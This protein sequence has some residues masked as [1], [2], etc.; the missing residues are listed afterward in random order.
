[1]KSDERAQSRTVFHQREKVTGCKP[2][3]VQ[4]AIEIPT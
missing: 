1:M 3:L 2:S 4:T